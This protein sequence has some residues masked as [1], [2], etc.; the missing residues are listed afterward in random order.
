MFFSD[1]KIGISMQFFYNILDRRLLSLIVGFYNWVDYL[2]KCRSYHPMI[3]NIT[4]KE[5]KCCKF[6]KIRQVCILV[7]QNR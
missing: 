3:L 2:A 4:I 6:K 7:A 1:I 5:L